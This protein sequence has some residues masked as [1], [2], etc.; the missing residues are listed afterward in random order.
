MV[1]QIPKT[2][3][4]S[5]SG[6]CEC[7][8]G[9]NVPR[10]W[11]IT[12]TASRKEER[13]SQQE[14]MEHFH[15]GAYGT[16]TKPVV[17]TM[18]AIAGVHII[19]VLKTPGNRLERTLLQNSSLIWNSIMFYWEGEGDILIVVWSQHG[20]VLYKHPSHS[21]WIN[22]FRKLPRNRR[23]RGLTPLNHRQ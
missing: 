23:L 22:L 14:A 12:T 21:I 10:I 16:S 3:S 2:W 8:W 5:R 7:V 17:I 19:L 1:L 6:V 18:S 20:Y 11:Q 9:C 4:E 13:R 15:L